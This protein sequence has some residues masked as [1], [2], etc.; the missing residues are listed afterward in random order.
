MYMYYHN[1]HMKLFRDPFGAIPTGEKVTLRLRVDASDPSGATQ[2]KPDEVLLRTWHRDQEELLEMRMVTAFADAASFKTREMRLSGVESS[3]TVPEAEKQPYAIAG[4]CR[5]YEHNMQWLYEVE[6]RIPDEPGLLWYYFIARTNDGDRFY[7]NNFEWFGGEGMF[8]LEPPPSYQ[9]T[10]Y[11]RNYTTP[12]W[13][14]HCVMYQIFPDRFFRGTA[15]HLTQDKLAQKRPDYILHTDWEEKPIHGADAR[16]GEVMNNDFFGGNLAGIIEKLPYLKAL[17][18]SVIYLNPI[19][20]AYSNHRYDTGNYRMIDATLGTKEDFTRLCSEAEKVGM[21]VILDGVFN[22]TGSDSLYFNKDGYY[23]ELGA[24]QS[25]ESKYYHWYQFEQHPDLYTSWWGILT[26]PN[27]NESNEDYVN[28]ILRE[29]DSV[30]RHWLRAG[31]SGW[32]LDVV[33]ELPDEF[34]R[35]LRERVKS[36]NPE[37]VIIGEVW[38]DASNKISY[39]KQREYLLGHELDSVMNYVFK[40]ALIHF[41]TERCAA[42]DFAAEIYRIYENYPRQTFYSLMNLV[43]GHDVPRI[44][45]VLSEPPEGLTKSQQAIYRTTD[46]KAAI[47]LKRL[48]IASLVQMT[49]PGVPSVYYGDEAGMTGLTDPFNRGTFPWGN[50]NEDLHEWYRSIIALRNE[51]TVLQ[52]GSFKFLHY[53]GNLLVFLRAIR[54][55]RDVF[56]DPA[57]DG[58]AVV[59]VNRSQTETEMVALDWVEWAETEFVDLLDEKTRKSPVKVCDG[60]LCLTVEPLGY[61]LLVGTAG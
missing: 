15:S 21:R 11:D 34:V 54:G 8:S 20:E 10:V 36:V 2:E 48:K 58:I 3:D 42:E 6:L 17:G 1:S 35:L 31:A 13:F 30:I 44:L 28:Y 55:G 33:D 45:S 22:H 56:G 27:V 50:I 59:A 43:G 29:D 18:I 41:L 52:T 46:K 23:E 40:E 24:Y 32:R 9:I 14:R 4:G 38:E 19:F 60:K 37:A 49:F 7:G 51:L 47:A 26:L 57:E 16:T 5:D 39:D 61:K 53:R 25:K 12:A